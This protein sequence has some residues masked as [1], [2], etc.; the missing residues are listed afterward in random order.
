MSEAQALRRRALLGRIYFLAVLPFVGAVIA[1]WVF[2]PQAGDPAPAFIVWSFTVLIF[3]NAFITGFV[4]ARHEKYVY[5][6][7]LIALLFCALGIACLLFFIAR[8][9]SFAP[10]A[11]L[12]VLHW[13]SWLWMQRITPLSSHTDK[14]HS[15]FIW[16]V[17]A[18]HMMVLL[19][20]IY[21][22]KTL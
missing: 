3:G 21:E 6:Q 11:V 18:C 12:T 15:R 17:L 7:G 20:L 14:Q 16:T 22:L 2:G 1:P 4:F 9:Q 5:L 13:L 19:N 10:V 8:Q